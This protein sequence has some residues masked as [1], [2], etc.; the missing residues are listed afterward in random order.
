MLIDNWKTVAA[1]AWSVRLALLSALLSGAEVA[2]SL[3][4]ASTLGLPDRS[5][6]MLAALT[7]TAAA[8]ARLFAQKGVTDDQA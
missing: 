6:A 1:R 3:L 7:A 2:L 5:F 4:D 8:M